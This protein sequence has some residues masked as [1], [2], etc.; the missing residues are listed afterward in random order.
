M[1]VS[2]DTLA[3]L[4]SRLSDDE[5]LKAQAFKLPTLHDRYIA[6]RGMLR[7]TV[8]GYLAADPATLKFVSGPYGKPALL[9][10]PLQFNIS[11]TADSLLIAVANF[12]DIGI[13]VETVKLRR[14]F[15]N[16]A[17]RCF[18]EREYQGW[19]ELPVELQAD[20]FYRLWTKKEAFVKAV[21]RGIALG[22][23]QCEFA[24]EAGG[25]LRTIP[26][27]YGSANAWLV[28]ELDVDAA[29]NPVL[30]FPRSGGGVSLAPELESGFG[31]NDC[32]EVLQ[33]R[34]RNNCAALVTPARCYALR[35]LLLQAD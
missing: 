20:A 26:D 18:S 3:R 22:L 7:E 4:A 25:Q 34:V 12:A 28:H 17:Q 2:A 11:H 14:N 5:M 30:S 27:E 9:D 21:G 35:R 13:D 29:V 15:E 16:L 6:A 31:G 24:L 32:S 19:C 1:S 10:E 23:E 8:A 33:N